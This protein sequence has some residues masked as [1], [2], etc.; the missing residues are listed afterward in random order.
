MVLEFEGFEKKSSKALIKTAQ[1]NLEKKFAAGEGWYIEE[2][3]GT[4]ALHYLTG[5]HISISKEVEITAE[6]ALS[7]KNETTTLVNILIN[8]NLY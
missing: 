1:A 5:N 7:L 6:E 2:S 3:K 8:Y 4:F